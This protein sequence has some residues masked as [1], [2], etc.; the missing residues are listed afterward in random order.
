MQHQLPDWRRGLQQG[1]GT[2]KD[3]LSAASWELSAQARTRE[4]GCFLG[5]NTYTCEEGG[6]ADP[7][8]ETG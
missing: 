1:Q 2:T 7:L 5:G 4:E 6:T 8:N 3:G